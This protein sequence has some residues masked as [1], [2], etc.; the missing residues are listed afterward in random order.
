MTEHAKAGWLKTS[1]GT[2]DWEAVFEAPENGLI[3]LIAQANSPQALRECAIVTIQMLFSRDNDAENVTNLT[4][5]L[6]EL[7]P[8]DAKSQ[9][10]DVF[11]NAITS[12]LRQIKQERIELAEEYVKNKK[13]E[14]EENAP[15][16]PVAAAPEPSVALP[17]PTN[18]ERRSPRKTNKPSLKNAKKRRRI[19]PIISIT[20]AAVIAIILGGGVYLVFGPSDT[21]V[22]AKAWAGW[23]KKAVTARLPSESWAI[24]S[25]KQGDGKTVVIEILISDKNHIAQIKST[26]RIARAEFLKSVCPAPDSGIS[27]MI[28][29]GWNLWIT[30]KSKSGNLTG[31]T[32]KY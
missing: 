26:R 2:T 20:A 10:L 29:V 22:A 3:P 25:A 32:C 7:V 14:E 11:S 1:D 18:T 6:N 31:G 16:V 9:Q 5:E 15:D 23:A 27:R 30:L 8:D 19:S 24:T 12:V 4:T 28:D 13:L 17:E 21:E